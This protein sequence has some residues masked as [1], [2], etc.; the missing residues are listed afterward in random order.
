M[1]SPAPKVCIVTPTYNHAPYLEECVRSALAQTFPDWEQIIVDD[2]ST[3]ATPEIAKSFRDPRVRYFRRERVGVYRLAET[4]NF[5]LSQ[6]KAPFVAI[7]EGDDVWTPE[8]LAVQLPKL[9][10]P[11][12][13]LAYA[14]I[15]LIVDGAV[16][17]HPQLTRDWS[18]EEQSNNPVGSALTPILSFE[19]LPDPGTWVVRR[20]ALD[21]IGGFR[22]SPGLPT[23]DYPTLLELCLKGRFAYTPRPL[24]RWRQHAAQTTNRHS[25]DLFLRA[26]D[27]ARSFYD[28]KIPPEIKAR[29]T[30]TPERLE[31]GLE[32]QRA[33]GLVRQG[34]CDLLDGR[35]TEARENFR[36]AFGRGTPFLNAASAVGWTASWLHVDIEACARVM[37]K[38]HFRRPSPPAEPAA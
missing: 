4:Y 29:L 1:A 11:E 28:E 32:R 12:V 19:G 9:D 20:S 24:T 26:A 27:H 14:E 8:N 34:R 10:D 35:W 31:R 22:Q 13:V 2:G 21:A 38:A 16:R 15:D 36:R 37:G 17:A 3:D 30:L 25:G 5:A 6:S 7:L 23:T 18:P 33:M